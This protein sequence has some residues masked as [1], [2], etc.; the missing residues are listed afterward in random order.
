MKSSVHTSERG[1]IL[2]HVGVALL[3]LIAFTMFVVDYGILWVSRSQAQNSADAGA[4]AG[5]VAMAFDNDDRADD[6]PAKLA[7]LNFAQA[8]DVFG[9]D[10]DVDV[11]TDIYFYPDDPTKFPPEC[12]D[13]T[14]IRVDV[15]RNQARGNPLPMWFGQLVGLTEQGVRASAIARAAQANASDC[16]K[17]FGIPDKW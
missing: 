2:I 10:P 15:Y 6:G 16:M 14:C 11:A 5:A 12:A 13:D 17:P 7:A 9:E 8:N 4:L 1:A 3:V